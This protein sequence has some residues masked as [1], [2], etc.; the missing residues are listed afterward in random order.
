MLVSKHHP[1]ACHSGGFVTCDGACVGVEAV[2]KHFVRNNGH[3]IIIVQK[4]IMSDGNAVVLAVA[5][6]SNVRDLCP[7]GNCGSAAREVGVTAHKDRVDIKAA[8]KHRQAA[9]SI[10]DFNEVGF[11]AAA[12]NAYRTCRE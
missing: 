12:G 8:V 10:S 4:L 1:F 7:V 6:D 11:K 3:S 5:A 2:E 9:F